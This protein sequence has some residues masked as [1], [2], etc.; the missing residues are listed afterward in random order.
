LSVSDLHG[1]E[2]EFSRKAKKGLE[3]LDAQISDWRRELGRLGGELGAA[4]E[5]A[6]AERVA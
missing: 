2:K 6:T 4:L 3:H 1:S 5:A